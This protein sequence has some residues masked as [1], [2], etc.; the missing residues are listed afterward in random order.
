MIAIFPLTYYYHIFSHFLDSS[1]PKYDLVFVEMFFYDCLIAFPH[2]LNAPFIGMVSQYGVPWA[3]DL[4]GNPSVYSFVPNFSAPYGQR[5]NFME[6]FYN[7]IFSVGMKLIRRF[8]FMTKQ[9]EVAMKYFGAEMPPLWEIERN[10]SLIFH[11]GHPA[12]TPFYPSMPNLVDVAGM[13]ILAKPPPLPQDLSNIMESNKKVVLFCLGSIIES[14][15]IEEER[16]IVILK[17]LKEVPYKVVWRWDGDIDKLPIPLPSNVHASKWLPQQSLLAHHNLACFVT[18]GGLLSLQETTY[19]GVPVVGF[20]FYGDQGLNIKHATDMGIGLS[21][22][23][24]TFT[25]D[26]LINSINEVIENPRYKKNAVKMS[27][28]FRDQLETSLERGVYWT[29]YVIRHNGAPH[30]RSAAVDLW[31]FQYYLIDVIAFALLLAFISIFIFC[32]IVKF[33]YKFICKK[34]HKSRKRLKRE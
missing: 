34:S 12:V 15:S 5:M 27:K 25:K 18:H 10:I 9:N 29:E 11:N 31:W 26:E 24:F 21:L 20:P 23:F 2:H 13:H 8:Y 16:L 28:I 7:T 19:H 14:S 22:K 32:T 3:S 4:V 6:R 33:V 17:A 1:S 30:L